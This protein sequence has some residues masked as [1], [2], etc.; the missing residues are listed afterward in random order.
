MCV[1]AGSRYEKRHMEKE[2]AK[3]AEKMKKKEMNR[4]IDFVQVCVCIYMPLGA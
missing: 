4:I 2:N 3:L 1:S